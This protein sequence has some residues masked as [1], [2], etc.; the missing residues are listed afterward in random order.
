MYDLNEVMF[1]GDWIVVMCD[2]CIVQIGMFE[3]ILMDLVNDYV[4][5]FVQDVDCVCVFIVVNVME[6]LCFVVLYI[7]GLCIVLCQMCDVYMLVIY[8]VGKDWQFVG[9][10]IDCDVVKFVCNG[11]IIFDLIIKFVL[12]SVCEDEVLMNLFVFVV[13]L[14]LLFV[15]MDVDGCLVGV[16]LCVMLF[17]VFGLGFGVIEEIIFLFM[18][19]LQVEI[20]V[21]LDDGWIVEFVFLLSLG[22]WVEMEE[23]C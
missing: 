20:D 10:V 23:V 11:V 1:F 19:M 15:V 21:V 7:V 9:V 13:E 18:L 4:E 22:I 17:V 2:G 14:F 16:I 3:D 6:C 12:Q 8:V 5:Q